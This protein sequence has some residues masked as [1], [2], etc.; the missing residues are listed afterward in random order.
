MGDA[1]EFVIRPAISVKLDLCSIDCLNESS[2]LVVQ[3][4]TRD[5]CSN[6]PSPNASLFNENSF[7][8]NSPS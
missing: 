2:V 8:N 4:L 5:T 7:D 6:S 1:A 3:L